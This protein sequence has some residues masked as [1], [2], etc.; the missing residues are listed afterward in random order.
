MEKRAIR[1]TPV[2]A[3]ALV[4]A[5]LCLLGAIRS[6]AAQTTNL[7]EFQVPSPSQFDLTG[8]INV[9]PLMSTISATGAISG[10]MFMQDMTI[11]PGNAPALTFNSVQDG[12]MFYFMLCPSPEW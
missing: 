2:P 6:V 9:G 7:P 8:N 11:T 4:V 1:R 3:L 10:D 5:S 12:M